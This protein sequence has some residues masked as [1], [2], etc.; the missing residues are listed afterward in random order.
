MATENKP[1]VTRS[2]EERLKTLYELQTIHNEIRR[3][4]EI[5][6]KLPEEV[7][8]L[9][10]T[11]QGLHTRIEKFKNEIDDLKNQS[12]AEANK[13][14]NKNLL[15]ERYRQQLDNVRNNHEF[16]NL[17]KEIEY[18]TLE[19]QLAEKNIG[20]IERAIANRENDIAVTE[21][22]IVDHSN[23]LEEKKADLERIVSET[24]SEEENLYA[25]A[26]SLE[27]A[28][29]ERTLT[30]FKRIRSKAHNGL[31]I[32]IVDRNACGGCFNR[33]PPQKQIEI[34][35]HKKVIVC[36]YCGRI[37]IDPALVTDTAE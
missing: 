37:M 32:V 35:T 11:I 20:E 23:I 7:K 25:R 19:I 13:I 15:I 14:A 29:D 9:E 28:I 21:Q 1:E 16:D 22:E 12:V 26:K 17:T 36:E 10:V 6:G 31:G 18:E 27:P 34:K 2:V 33:I 3:I 4:R 5:R 30:A 24:R 8:E